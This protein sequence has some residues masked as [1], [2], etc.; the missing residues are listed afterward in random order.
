MKFKSFLIA[1]LIVSGAIFTFYFMRVEAYAP[2]ILSIISDTRFMLLAATAFGLILLGH[3]VRAFKAKKLLDPVKKSGVRTQFQ[4]LLIGYLFNTLLPL[5]LGEIM[6]A[7]ILGRSLKTSASLLFALIL[8]ERSVDALILGLI[9]VT[10]GIYAGMPEAISQSFIIFGISLLAVSALLIGLIGSLKNHNRYILRFWYHSTA[11]LNTRLK[12]SLRFKMWSVIYG[13]QKLLKKRPLITYFAQSLAMWTCYLTALVVLG[14]F[15]FADGPVFAFIRSIAAYLG[16]LIPSGPAYLGAYQAVVDPLFQSLS[17]GESSTAYL[18][19]SWLIITI[20]SSLIGA[21]LLLRHHTSYGKLMSANDPV[22]LQDKLARVKDA[23][24]EFEAFL[25]SFFSRNTL[26]H[27]LHRIEIED[28]IK[29]IKYFKGGSDASTILVHQDGNYIVKKITPKQYAHRLQAQHNWLKERSHLKCI[30][31]VVGEQEAKDYY[32]IDIE[33][34]PEMIPFFDYLHSSDI[35]NSKEILSQVFAY[36]HENVYVFDKNADHTD[37]LEDYI[38]NKVFEKLDQASRLNPE[39]ARLREYD[40]IHVNGRECLNIHL[41]I[42][43]IRRRKDIWDDLK[44][45]RETPIHGDTQIDNLL[46]SR[47]DNSFLII[48]PVDQNEVSSAVIDFGRMTQS[49]KYGYE[50]L[51]KDD[52][53]VHAV[54]NRIDYEDSKSAAYEDLYR[55]F[56]KLKKEL[57]TPKEYRAVL[58]HTAVHYSRMSTHRVGINPNN[59]AKFYAVSVRA[60]N[61]FLDQYEPK[62]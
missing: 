21:I 22:T 41:A 58:F 36:L 17:P 28:N 8:V 32:A 48:D 59:V 20:P 19:A 12:N 23:S 39:L 30:V 46:A 6:R 45:Y 56:I 2:E 26:S 35:K 53:P 34:Y 52:A 13:L 33:Y 38:H 31:G 49:L 29:L 7:W 47:K 27:I 14:A 43:E 44:T 16:V 62:E 11:L 9:V 50:F 4:A 5:R 57:L 40:T 55:H 25:D 3:A 60:F 15:F 24:Q 10:L 18:I 51:C 1:V 54:E 42:K 37:K 61:D